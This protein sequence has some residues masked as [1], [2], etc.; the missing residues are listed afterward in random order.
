MFKRGRSLLIQ[1]IGLDYSEFSSV[2]DSIFQ[3]ASWMI[4]METLGAAQKI[5]A[6]MVEIGE[7]AALIPVEAR[8]ATSDQMKG[9]AKRCVSV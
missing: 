1:S 7:S 4:D 3:E 9:F 2:N 6:G 8:G 5:L